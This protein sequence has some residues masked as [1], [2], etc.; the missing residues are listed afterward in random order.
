[1]V[2]D[3]WKSCQMWSFVIQK[4]LFLK[5]L[6]IPS[7]AV[8]VQ[9]YSCPNAL[10]PRDSTTVLPTLCM[11]S[12]SLNGMQHFS[13][14]P[15]SPT[16]MIMRSNCGRTINSSTPEMWLWEELCDMQCNCRELLCKVGC[17]G[18]EER[19]NESNIIYFKNFLRIASWFWGFGS[20][21]GAGNILGSSWWGFSTQSVLAVMLGSRNDLPGGY[22]H[23][24]ELQSQKAIL[25]AI[26][27]VQAHWHIF[28]LVPPDVHVTL[29]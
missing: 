27:L 15:G 1:M 24:G 10:L 28:P 17:E 12:W 23:A 8:G 22:R 19:E 9:S 5:K 25:W 20:W 7:P 2:T 21:L 11:L 29:L 6:L 14:S 4:L 13:R 3:G 26:Y 16:L 18:T